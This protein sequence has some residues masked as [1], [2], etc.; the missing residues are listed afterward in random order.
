LKNG[1]KNKTVCFSE[2]ITGTGVTNPKTV[3]GSSLSEG[4][5]F[6]DNNNNNNKFL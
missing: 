4:V 5:G 2:E 6:R 1:A 3:V